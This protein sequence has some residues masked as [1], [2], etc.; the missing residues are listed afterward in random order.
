MRIDAYQPW[1]VRLVVHQYGEVGAVVGHQS[2][3]S[4]DRALDQDGIR[5]ALQPESIHMP[6]MRETP[7]VRNVRQSRAQAF[8][9][10]EL[11]RACARSSSGVSPDAT[12]LRP[13]QNGFRRGRPRRG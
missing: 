12:G 9:D 4:V 5:L 3:A 13:R 11:Q 2:V 7:S 10:E 6:G 8:V 1:M